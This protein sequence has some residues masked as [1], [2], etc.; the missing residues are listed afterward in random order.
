MVPSCAALSRDDVIWAFSFVVGA[1]YS[2]QLIDHR[3]DTMLNVVA[4]RSA[5]E[6][7]SDIVA[8]CC[9]G[10]EAICERRAAQRATDEP[11]LRIAVSA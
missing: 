3:Y 8:F 11:P 4:E 6:V 9:K 2:W 1:V 7:T 5:H 10:I